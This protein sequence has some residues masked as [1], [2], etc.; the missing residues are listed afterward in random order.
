MK[1][2]FRPELSITSGGAHSV[3]FFYIVNQFHPVL[4]PG[5]GFLRRH[6]LTSKGP[7]LFSGIHPEP[8][9]KLFYV[10]SITS[11]ATQ[12]F[13]FFMH[14]VNYIRNCKGMVS[15]KDR[16]CLSLALDLRM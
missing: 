4:Q 9:L 10:L 5:L 14:I 6:L 1:A 2:I 7:L 16:C 3:Q 15:R 13:K 11:G 8:G 12:V